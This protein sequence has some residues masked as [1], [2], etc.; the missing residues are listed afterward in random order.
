MFLSRNSS[1]NL[2][3]DDIHRVGTQAVAS[4]S[5]GLNSL[6]RLP[7]RKRFRRSNF[8]SLGFQKF[9]DEHEISSAVEPKIYGIICS[10]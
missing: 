2:G 9:A 8:L 4:I 1:G 3:E 10:S 6:S 5:H 7:K